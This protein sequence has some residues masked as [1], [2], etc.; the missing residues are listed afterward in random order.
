MDHRDVP[1][2]R[3]EV[4]LFEKSQLRDKG[5]GL[6]VSLLPAL[7]LRVH[8]WRWIVRRGISEVLYCVVL[9]LHRRISGV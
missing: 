2:A 5:L 1:C 9:A 3:G 4:D 6:G 8:P 7:G